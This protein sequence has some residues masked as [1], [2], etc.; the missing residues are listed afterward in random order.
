[1]GFDRWKKRLSG[2]GKKKPASQASA[3][4]SGP[5][6]PRDA[7][8]QNVS[9]YPNNVPHPAVAENPP[10]ALQQAAGQTTK[11][12]AWPLTHP[13]L[14]E[15]NVQ[16]LI[17]Y[18]TI[19]SAV[20]GEVNCW[21]YISKGLAQVGQKEIVFTIRRRANELEDNLPSAPFQWI[22]FVYSAAKNGQT[23]EEFQ[24]TEFHSPS[25]LDRPDFKWIVYCP[26]HP[27]ADIPASYFPLEWLQ[28]I[29]LIA[30]EAE[31]AQRYGI[32]RALGHLGAQ[33]RWFP[34]PPWI[35]RDRQPCITM[36]NMVGTMKESL[37]LVIVRGVSALKRGMDIVLHVPQGCALYLKEAL[38]QFQL[39]HVFALDSTP[40]KDADSGLLWSNTDTEPRGYAAGTSNACMNLNYFAF[41]PCQEM[42]ELKMVEDGFIFM[43]TNPT[44][45]SLRQHIEQST[46]TNIALPSGL[47][48]ILEF[49]HSTPTR[50]NG[51]FPG[52]PVAMPPSVTFP[53]EAGFVQYNPQNPVPESEK[54]A[55]VHCDHIVLLDNNI[56]TAVDMDLVTNYIKSIEKVLDETVPKTIPLSASGGGKLLIEADVGGPDRDDVISREWVKMSF[57]PP[58][59]NALPMDQI[60]DGVS[61]VPKPDIVT[62]TKFSLAFN[63]WGFRGPWSWA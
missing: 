62:R 35:D 29:P 27:I 10:P 59:L 21:T 26:A 23:V 32:M 49:G 8:Q 36:A 11:A 1:M 25:F 17:F 4:Y 15:E 6:S 3:S 50:S 57:S 30:P 37:P 13:V 51:P 33:E 22:K 39:E 2:L 41:C 5:S 12:I 58:Y 16:A 47:H 60:Y 48:F 40:H 44:W 54:P 38:A 43:I 56:T 34:F 53:P 18:H 61:R 7:T 42:N 46:S 52:P 9:P 20:S 19:K 14:P 63:V 31:V 55:H 28:V 24:R 45:A